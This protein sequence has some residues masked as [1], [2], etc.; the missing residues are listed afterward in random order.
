MSPSRLNLG[1]RAP[2]LVLWLSGSQSKFPPLGSADPDAKKGLYRKFH[3]YALLL[4]FFM[5][6]YDC[7][8]SC[9]IP[10]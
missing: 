10:P 9:A 1:K 6:R 4:V 7:V 5:R 8:S 3:L 2:H